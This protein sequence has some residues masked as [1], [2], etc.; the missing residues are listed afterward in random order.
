MRQLQSFSILALSVSLTGCASIGFS[1]DRFKSGSVTYPDEMEQD[2]LLSDRTDFD[3][4]TIIPAVYEKEPRLSKPIDIEFYDGPNVEGFQAVSFAQQEAIVQP[5]SHNYLN[6]IQL[7]PYAEGSLYQVYTSP[8]Q[9]TDIALQKGEGC[10]LYTSPSPRDA[11]LSRMP[12]S[13]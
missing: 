10:L 7:Y 5:S 6:A 1:L 4:I 9:V 11:T 13:A 3:E 12:S 8:E 2:V